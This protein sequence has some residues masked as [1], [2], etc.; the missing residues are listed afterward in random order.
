M[1]EDGLHLLF[2]PMNSSGA[3]FSDFCSMWKCATAVIFDNCADVFEVSND[4]RD[5]FW[6]FYGVIFSFS[7]FSPYLLSK[8]VIVEVKLLRF[9]G[10]KKS[11][12]FLW[13][14]FLP[15]RAT[16]HLLISFSFGGRGVW[17]LCWFW[18]FITTLWWIS[19][20]LKH[21][22]CYASHMSQ[23]RN[24]F[25]ELAHVRRYLLKFQMQ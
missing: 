7:F 11:L 2:L 18:C 10:E 25:A 20:S 24:R 21:V 9:G 3:K 22:T 4:S 5:Y 19:A 8:A 6:L 17:L 13:N 15:V 16:S 12:M 23:N 14:Y 1:S